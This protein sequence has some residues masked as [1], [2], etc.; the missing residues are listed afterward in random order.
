MDLDTL[1]PAGLQSWG[2]SAGEKALEPRRGC[3]VQVAGEE[4]PA[5]LSE[6]GRPEILPAQAS[7]RTQPPRPGKQPSR[8]GPVWGRRGQEPASGSQSSPLLGPPPAWTLGEPPAGWVGAE[9]TQGC[10]KGAGRS[11]ASPATGAQHR[12][13]GGARWKLATFIKYSFTRCCHHPE[14]GKKIIIKIGLKNQTTK[15]MKPSPQ[16]SRCR[17]L[18]R[19]PR[20]SEEA[21]FLQPQAPEE[22]ILTVAVG[23]P[24]WP[25]HP[26]EMVIAGRRW[27]ESCRPVPWRH[28]QPGWRPVLVH[29]VTTSLR[30]GADRS[31]KNILPREGSRCLGRPAAWPSS[32]G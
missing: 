23:S 30:K 12:N 19:L 17:P 20:T 6:G 32:W 13:D 1:P 10:A 5:P 27:A 14:Q 25:P 8:S 16:Q 9:A 31:R 3:G 11:R 4:G 7:P 2:V 29:L 26:Q 22:L 28:Y 21:P 15:Q 18:A 24:W